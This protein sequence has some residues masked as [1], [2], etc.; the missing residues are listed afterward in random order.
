MNSLT[1]CVLSRPSQAI[2]L[3]VVITLPRLVT[4]IYCL[5][6]PWRCLSP[7][8][9]TGKYSHERKHRLL[10][11][12]KREER[13]CSEKPRQE[14]TQ[15]AWIC[16]RMTGVNLMNVPAVRCP[17]LASVGG[18]AQKR[19]AYS[20]GQQRKHA[21]CRR[22]DVK[23]KDK[24]KAQVQSTGGLHLS[25][26]PSQLCLLGLSFGVPLSGELCVA[27]GWG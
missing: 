11:K 16:K 1:R 26:S 22:A 3:S 13:S 2:S 19:T 12:Q 18:G 9:Q 27:P 23:D 10:H 5:L 8:S 15:R 24:V 21:Q 20:S 4:Q 6:G 14:H 7:W 25:L 17:R